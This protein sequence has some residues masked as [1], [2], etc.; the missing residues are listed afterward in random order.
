MPR[1]PAKE[2]TPRE[3]EVMHVFWTHGQLTAAEARTHLAGAGRDLT[4][5]TVATLVRLLFEKGFL[6]QLNDERPFVY[7]PARSH[8]EV[9]KRLLG[10]VLDCVFKGSREQLLLRLFEQ[11]GLTEQ[12]RSFLQ[13]ILEEPS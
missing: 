2:L 4:Y 5:T 12:E 9:S 13:S 7:A 11:G 6:Q 8:E 3:L 1:I 10:D